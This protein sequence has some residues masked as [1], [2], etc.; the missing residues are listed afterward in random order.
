MPEIL[1]IAAGILGLYFW[2]QKEAAGNLIFFPGTITGMAFEDATPV[3]F[4]T[5]QIQNTSNVDIQI[6]SMA[7]NVFAN[8]VRVG[9]VSNFDPVMIGRNSQGY[10]PIKVQFDL[11]GI[12]Q[13]IIRAWQGGVFRQTISIEG[14][15][16]AGSVQVPISL[17]FKVS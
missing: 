12:V 17:V 10:L 16:N 6:N 3:A 11:I 15:V 7:G 14:F 13:D 5:L 9:N 4:L 2:K 8:G 1:L